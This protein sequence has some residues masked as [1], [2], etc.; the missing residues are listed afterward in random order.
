MGEIVTIAE[1]KAFSKTIRIEAL[2]MVH[3]S[4]SSHIGGAFSMA[5]ILAVLYGN[6]MH[7]KPES[8]QWPERD[9]FLLSKG[10]ACSTLY[11]ALALR[12]F[13]DSSQLTTFAQ[14]GSYFTSHANHHIP[15]VELSTGSL[16]HALSFGCGLAL[17][18]KRR[19]QTWRV[20]ALLSDGEL[21]EGSNW[22]AFLFAPHHRL[23][24]LTVIIDHNKIQSL[25]HVHEVLDLGPLAEKFKSF[26]WHV[27]V[28]DGHDHGAL[29]KVLSEKSGDLPHIIIA[30]TIKGKGVDFMEGR[31]LWHYRTPNT[32]QFQNALVQLER[33]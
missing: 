23:N 4:N 19:G 21:D 20:Y 10:H 18:A 24:N 5:D 22:E 8:P 29:L 14:N 7:V 16:G 32:D 12:G 31:L 26:G 13:F 6:V 28:V 33:S 3:A 25:G 15:G 27:S 2:K 1:L 9:R 30:E 11:A 17:A